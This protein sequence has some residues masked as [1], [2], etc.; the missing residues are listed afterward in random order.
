[1]FHWSLKR[2]NAVHDIKIVGFFFDR[3]MCMNTGEY[4]FLKS[5]C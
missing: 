3:C 2:V 5:L 1:M 4:T